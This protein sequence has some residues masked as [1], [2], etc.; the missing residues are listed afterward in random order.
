MTFHRFYAENGYGYSCN[1]VTAEE[2]FKY[3]LLVHF[4]ISGLRPRYESG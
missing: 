2:H 3:N 4:A 1:R